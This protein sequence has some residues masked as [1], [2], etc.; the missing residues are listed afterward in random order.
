MIITKMRVPGA[1][2]TAEQIA[3]I[4]RA[5]KLPFV[6]D[7]ECPPMTEEQLAEFK[8]LYSDR[9]NKAL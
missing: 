2:P 3:M 5:K 4:E 6:Y 1:K 7:K 8:P 9:E